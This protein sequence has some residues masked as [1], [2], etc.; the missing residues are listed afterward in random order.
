MS[1]ED[2]KKL[3]V[4]KARAWCFTLNN[5][6]ELDESNFVKWVFKKPKT[7]MYRIIGKE[8]GKSGTKHLQGY[9]YFK[10]PI[11]FNTI[12]GLLPRAH[13]EVAKGTAEDNKKYCSKD[14][15]ILIEEGQMPSQ[16]K[17]T[18]LI[19]IKDEILNGKK[20][21]KIV[22]ENP[23]LYHQYGRTFN[24][25]EDLA[26][27]KK[28]RTEMTK[29]IWYFGPTGVGKSHKA[30]E[31]FNPDTHYV[32]PDD[33]G[34][35]DG[36]TQQE[37]VIFNDFRGEVSYNFLLQLVDKWPMWVKRRNREPMPF[38]SKRVVITSSLPPN[39]IFKKRTA[40]DSIAQMLR[41]FSIIF[42]GNNGTEVL[43][44]NTV[45][46]EHDDDLYVDLNIPILDTS[47][48]SCGAIAP[49]LLA[50]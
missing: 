9:L 4:Y 27:R 32:V 7:P 15:N 23:E 1:D 38:I 6:S 36:Y 33:N 46:P 14:G 41:R 11:S 13:I 42:L 47:T 26:M 17:R 31:N 29:G 10:N 49:G 16:G 40:E 48:G 5:Y 12:K 21:D 44:G 8:V 2:L 34:W 18:D 30:F 28:F 3:E 24:K 50:I 19:E 45:P 43:W 20:V 22:L 35:W 25:I 37:T 39:K